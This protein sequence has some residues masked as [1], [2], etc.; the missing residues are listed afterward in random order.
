M[1]KRQQEI[2]PHKNEAITEEKLN[3][4]GTTE[5]ESPSLK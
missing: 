2:F 4:D 1:L 5:E 3:V